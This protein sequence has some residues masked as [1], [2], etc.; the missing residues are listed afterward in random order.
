ML[1]WAKMGAIWLFCGLILACA[2]ALWRN[3]LWGYGGILEDIGE[4]EMP[5]WLKFGIC[6]VNDIA[7]APTW[8][9]IGFL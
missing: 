3:V 8:G 9:Q 6:G 7:S 1:L 4:K 2:R 5:H